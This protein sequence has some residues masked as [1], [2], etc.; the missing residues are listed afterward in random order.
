MKAVLAVLVGLVVL[1]G[2]S[3]GL[4]GSGPLAEANTWECVEYNT[5][6]SKKCLVRSDYECGRYCF[7]AVC[8]LCSDGSHGHTYCD[9]N[10]CWTVTHRNGVSP[11]LHWLWYLWDEP[12][13]ANRNYTTFT[14]NLQMA[15]ML[16]AQHPLEARCL[17]EGVETDLLNQHNYQ[18]GTPRRGFVNRIGDSAGHEAGGHL[19]GTLDFPGEQVKAGAVIPRLLN[20]VPTAGK[21][22]SFRIHHDVRAGVRVQYRAWPY[23]GFVPDT[24]GDPFRDL[25]ASR[26]V[27][28]ELE[29]LHSFQVRTVY[30]GGSDDE[31]YGNSNVVN[32]VAG[33][34]SA[35]PGFKV[36]DP[37]FTPRPAATPWA[38]PDPTSGFPRPNAPEIRSV[39]EDTLVAGLMRIVM[40]RPLDGKLEYRFWNHTG[41][42]LSDFD[43]GWE[44]APA[45][46][47]NDAFTVAVPAVEMVKGPD[48]PLLG[49]GFVK[50][51][52]WNFEHPV[53]YTFQTRVVRVEG[54]EPSNMVVAL[55][56]TPR[57]QVVPRWSGG[58]PAKGWWMMRAFKALFLRA[59][60]RSIYA[61]GRVQEGRY[62]E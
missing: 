2:L 26:V 7:Y 47:V 51:R 11:C 34:N 62:G 15:F 38:L 9:E 16:G 17:E 21:D 59:V 23:T 28:V 61:R 44:A 56:W 43:G 31:V 12:L 42:A 25:P 55:A 48:D 27:D 30:G 24:F 6:Y 57:P 49:S 58:R 18:D 35:D 14:S 20:V 8:T 60:G 22:W 5:D 3:G 33:M 40:K 36:G 1:T 29:G 46:D 52:Y 41:F 13:E 32:K 10:G 39:V 50:P 45:L 37:E 19:S 54:S 4:L 53:F